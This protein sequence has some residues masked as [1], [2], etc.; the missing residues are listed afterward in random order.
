VLWAAVLHDNA[1]GGLVKPTI[2]IMAKSQKGGSQPPKKKT[3]GMYDYGNIHTGTNATN[4]G[5]LKAQADKKKS[6]ENLAAHKKKSDA[7]KAAAI[8]K[9]QGKK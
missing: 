1:L 8:K 9:A 5:V 2:T 7:Q 4:P 3:S 6:D